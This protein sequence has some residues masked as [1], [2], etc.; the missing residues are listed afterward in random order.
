MAATDIETLVHIYKIGS[1]SILNDTKDDRL[2]D[3]RNERINV[4]Q[5]LFEICTRDGEN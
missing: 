4:I 3:D 2:D 5:E 1:C